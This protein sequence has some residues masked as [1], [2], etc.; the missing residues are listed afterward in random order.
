[1]SEKQKTCLRGWKAVGAGLALLGAA[2]LPSHAAAQQANQPAGQAA[3]ASSDAITVVRDAETGKLRA[4][5]GQELET[6]RVA[7]QA[8]TVRATP[9]STQQKFHANGA[10]GVRLTDEFVSTAVAVRNAKGGVDMQCLEAGH[11]AQGVHSAGSHAN[12]PVEE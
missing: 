12:Q 4:P 8:R 9:A 5:T 6:L 11:S 2:A 10:T 1:M 7:A 3:T